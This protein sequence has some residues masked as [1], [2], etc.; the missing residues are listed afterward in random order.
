M[1]QTFVAPQYI[2]LPVPFPPD[3]G[4]GTPSPSL[5]IEIISDRFCVSPRHLFGIDWLGLGRIDARLVVVSAMAHI[6]VCAEANAARHQP[7]HVKDHVEDH[8]ADPPHTCC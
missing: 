2:L 4:G 3:L 5:P 7:D 6:V 1:L 8:V